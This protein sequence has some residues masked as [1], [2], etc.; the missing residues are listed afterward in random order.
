VTDA[1]LRDELERELNSVA[2]PLARNAW[3]LTAAVGLVERLAE[4]LPD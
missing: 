3:K 1:L 2:H 4:Q